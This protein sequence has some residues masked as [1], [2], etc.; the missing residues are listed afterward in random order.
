VAA[1]ERVLDQRLHSLRLGDASVEFCDL[2]LGQVSQDSG[3]LAL[4]GEHAT[5]L[6]EREPRVLVE[7]GE[8]NALRDRGRVVRSLAGALCGWEQPIRS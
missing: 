7:A 3:S 2:A 4:G 8:R 6:L 5:N 1:F